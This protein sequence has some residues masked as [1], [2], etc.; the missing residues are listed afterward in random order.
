MKRRAEKIQKVLAAAGICSRK[1]A[2]SLI[3]DGLVRLNGRVVDDP[4]LRVDPHAEVLEYRG[5]RVL[6]LEEKPSCLLLYKTAG[7][8]TSAADPHNRR[9]VYQLLPEK[10]RDRRWL[11]VGRLDKNSEGL[12]LFTDSGE[13][14]HRLAHPSFKVPKRYRVTV[15]DRLE[16]RCLKRLLDGLTIEGKHMKADRARIV[17]SGSKATILEITLHQGYKRQIRRMLWEL[18][19][20]VTALVRTGFGPLTLKG[21]EPGKCR[22]LSRREID[23]LLEREK[24][25]KTMEK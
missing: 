19:F 2:E 7:F 4:A 24:T 18:G 3:R 5:E 13:L 12:L 25:D 8:V 15:A 9:T 22:K 23:S 6:P 21:L 11:Y 16:T 14:A 1:R 17:R 20:K 10:E